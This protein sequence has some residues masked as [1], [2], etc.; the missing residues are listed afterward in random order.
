M[1]KGTI[2]YMEKEK[3]REVRKSRAAGSGSG[4]LLHSSAA[5]SA[6]R[7][8]YK[9][10]AC[11]ACHSSSDLLVG[12]G[13]RWGLPGVAVACCNRDASKIDQQSRLAP[14]HA[15]RSFQ[16]TDDRLV[17]L[18]LVPSDTSCLRCCYSHRMVSLLSIP[19]WWHGE[20]W[21]RWMWRG[22]EFS[23]IN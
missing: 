19:G 21:W 3:P 23:H 12:T 5:A 11:H 15:S 18:T 2:R 1:L 22:R 17:P 4:Y 14:A 8:R 20:W 13:E 16:G 7:T 6:P 10:L 9:N